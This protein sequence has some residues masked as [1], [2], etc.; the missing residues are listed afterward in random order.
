MASAPKNRSLGLVTVGQAPRDDLVPEMTRWLG[1]VRTL[2]RGVLDGLS[3]EEIADLRPA[4][5]DYA[6]VSRLRD[7]SPVTVAKRHVLPRVQAAIANLKEEGAGT[8]LLL[9]TGEF[10][11]FEH[12]R[13]LL[14][15]DRLFVGGVRAVACGTRLG[16]VCPL[17][18]QKRIT[19]E[20]W[21]GVSTDLR[22]ATGSPY[23][24]EPDELRHAARE[25]MEAG[26]EYVVL[27]CMGYTRKMKDLVRE[28]TGA[29][30]L[31]ARS[32]V[33]RLA[34]AVP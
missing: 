1:S 23:D 31:L 11:V 34:A 26:V 15:A 8:V 28:E 7:G 33:A 13:S 14:M 25:L 10:P 32:V 30:A 12:R 22:I 27:D 9:C 16:V 4:P 19:R 29:P 5:G 21:S 6:L 18:E 2:E 20:K 24:D 3:G 17:P